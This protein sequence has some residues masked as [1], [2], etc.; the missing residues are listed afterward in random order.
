MICMTL[1]ICRA[2]FV[3][4]LV[5]FF[6]SRYI[7][8]R[9]HDLINHNFCRPQKHPCWIFWGHSLCNFCTAYMIKD[10]QSFYNRHTNLSPKWHN[11]SF[12][13]FVYFANFFWQLISEKLTNARAEHHQSSVCMYTRS[14]VYKKIII[15][16]IFFSINHER[17]TKIL[18]FW[19]R[20]VFAADYLPGENNIR[21]SISIFMGFGLDYS[22][23]LLRPNNHGQNLISRLMVLKP[24]TWWT[25]CVAINSNVRWHETLERNSLFRWM[26]V[27]SCRERR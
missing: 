9:L 18:S 16:Q 3:R 23:V 24:A 19:F 6:P 11:L 2:L 8:I 4:V 15:C 7:R 13:I 14:R 21:I 25:Q 17:K 12:S 5:M 22:T 26:F 10:T 1:A 27:L 20:E